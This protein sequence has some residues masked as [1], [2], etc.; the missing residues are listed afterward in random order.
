MI[1]LAVGSNVITVE[2]TA[3]DDS[4]T[5]TYTVTSDT[6]RASINGR[7]PQ[8]PDPDRHRLR[9]VCVGDDFVHRPGRQWRHGDDRYS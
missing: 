7:G 4:T 6:L 5:Q 2:V 8:R 1:T 9:H 3:E